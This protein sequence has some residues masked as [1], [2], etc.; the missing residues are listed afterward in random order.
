[1]MSAILKVNDLI[2]QIMKSKIKYSVLLCGKYCS[3]YKLYP[4]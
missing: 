1:M 4:L 2:I 3:L